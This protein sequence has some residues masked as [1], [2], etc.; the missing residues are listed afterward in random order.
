MA[1]GGTGSRVLKSLAMLA[2]A[3]VR[4]LDA[5]TGKPCEELEIVPIVIDPH[6]AG[7]DVK[8]T[9]S[10][11]LHYRALRRELYGDEHRSHGFFSIKISTLRD[12]AGEN[13]GN[14]T[15]SFMLNLSAVERQRF[16]EFID[17]SSMDEA[18]QAMMSLLYSDSQLDTSMNIGFVG[19]PNIGSV[20]LNQLKDSEE[21]RAL[22]NIFGENDR[23]FFV[24]SIFG[25]TG[26]AG[27]PIM[28]KNIRNAA[29]LEVANKGHLAA[30][31]IGAL[32]VLPY[33]NIEHSD[34]SLINK[35][36]FIIKTRSAL[37]YYAR[38]MTDAESGNPM[39]NAMYYL[40][41]TIFSSPYANDPGQGGQ[42][43]AAHLIELIGALS[44]LHFV[45]TPDADL[46]PGDVKAFEYGLE[47]SGNKV[48][49]LTFGPSTRRLLYKPMLKLHLLSVF[50]GEPLREYIG[51]GFTNDAPAIRTD[52]LSS[53]FYRT[54]TGKF[55]P[56]YL[57]W[58]E[59]MDGNHRRVS[60]FDLD[61]IDKLQQ[62]VC[63]VEPKRGHLGE[64]QVTVDT[65][66]AG[67]NACSLH[68]IGKYKADRLP[69][70]LLDLFDEMADSL[71]DKRYA[72]V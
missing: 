60:L 58:L 20:A 5:A 34:K 46:R 67:M 25:G 72:K 49:I 4:P 47:K 10:I 65:L 70:K 36:D 42:K 66:F 62:V 54:L 29:H 27:F 39:V 52:F 40:G 43:N 6:R 44:V 17:Y 26:A 35:A 30:S 19:A 15:D 41:D 57:D 2:A 48:D 16:R 13:G 24:S 38:T 1:I 18:N 51:R 9:E 31:R 59:E 53:P 56:H 8:R 37:H 63:G 23:I 28:V 32:T 69:L 68:K 7:L 22:G 33:F 55:M 11:L 21:F 14:L 12:V 64:K 71:I 3:G 61:Q 45:G 50:A